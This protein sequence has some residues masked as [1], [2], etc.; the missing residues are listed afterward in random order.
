MRLSGRVGGAL[1]GR[2]VLLSRDAARWVHIDHTDVLRP[3]GTHAVLPHRVM[4]PSKLATFLPAFTFGDVRQL[5]ETR[6]RVQ[7]P[8][9]REPVV[10][11]DL[12]IG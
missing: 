2:K 12:T 8:P 3:E 4:A 11:G 6:R 10:P 5:E 9:T 1:P 7:V